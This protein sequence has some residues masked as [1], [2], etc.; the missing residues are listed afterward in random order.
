MRHPAVV[1]AVTR[2]ANSFLHTC[3]QVTPYE[4][5]VEVCEALNAR[6]PGTHE[7]RSML[8]NSGAEAVENTVKIARAATGPAR[9]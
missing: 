3:F 1:E 8:V 6:T 5:Y 7:K 2:Q 9:R 4:G